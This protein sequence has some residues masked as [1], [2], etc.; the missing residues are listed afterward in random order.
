MKTQYLA[1]YYMVEFECEMRC[2]TSSYKTYLS[3][4]EA[5]M[6]SRFC[7][8]GKFRIVSVRLALEIYK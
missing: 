2:C 6:M 4:N 8:E 3:I 7:A 5:R 1:G